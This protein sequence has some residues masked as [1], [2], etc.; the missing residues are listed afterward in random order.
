MLQFHLTPI[1]TC[2]Y[3]YIYIYNEFFHDFFFDVLSV[4]GIPRL[5]KDILYLHLSHEQ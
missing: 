1:H 5:E 2:A 3:M 4:I